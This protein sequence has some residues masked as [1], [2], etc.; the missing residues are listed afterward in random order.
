MT[1]PDDAGARVTTKLSPRSVPDTVARL[2]EIVEVRGLKLFA[3]IDHSG[4]AAASGMELRD[5]KV[6]IFGS[7][8]AGTPVMQAAPLAALDLPLKVLI[9]DD[10]GQTTL[11]YTAPAAGGHATCTYVPGALPAGLWVLEPRRFGASV[12][13]PERSRSQAT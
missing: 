2:S 11:A 7:P 10:A 5:A 6:V 4:E 9:W 12:S 13:S 1:A 8:Q 3:V